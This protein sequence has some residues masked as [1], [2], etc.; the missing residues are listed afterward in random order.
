MSPE[1]QLENDLELRDLAEQALSEMVAATT[2]YMTSLAAHLRNLSTKAKSKK[3]KEMLTDIVNAIHDDKYHILEATYD[4][5]RGELLDE[6]TLSALV[7]DE[8]EGKLA[9]DA[10]RLLED[11]LERVR[12]H[13]DS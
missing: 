7:E 9:S 12:L 11:H 4:L 6:D 13:K 1:E 10:D 3:T 8:I 5:I 2:L